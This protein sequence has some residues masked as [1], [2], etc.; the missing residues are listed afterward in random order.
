MGRLDKDLR[1]SEQISRG[2]A[3]TVSTEVDPAGRD[4]NENIKDQWLLG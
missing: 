3:A 1:L 2:A 4:S